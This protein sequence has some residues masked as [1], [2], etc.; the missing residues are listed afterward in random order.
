MNLP[1]GVSLCVMIVGGLVIYG[2]YRIGKYVAKVGL[3][4]AIEALREE[5][6]DEIEDLW[7]FF[8]DEVEFEDEE[9]KS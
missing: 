1:W 5:L 2:S 8:T 9:E 6:H 3:D 7:D 4:K